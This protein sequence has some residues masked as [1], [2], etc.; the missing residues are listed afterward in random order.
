MTADMLNDIRRWFSNLQ[1]GE[2][3]VYEPTVPYEFIAP[4]DAE[5]FVLYATKPRSVLHWLGHFPWEQGMG[6]MARYGLPDSRDVAFLRRLMERA[7][8]VFLGDL[9]PPDLLIYSW[10]H[11]QLPGIRYFGVGDRLLNVRGMA[12]DPRVTIQLATVEREAMRTFPSVFANL[13]PVVGPRCENLLNSGYKLETEGAF[14]EI[15]APWTDEMRVLVVEAIR[16][17]ATSAN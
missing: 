13:A 11:A 8:V 9:D 4:S 14:S 17:C 12:P 2:F 15:E 6:M 3:V 5:G 7:P 16:T 10:L 1:D